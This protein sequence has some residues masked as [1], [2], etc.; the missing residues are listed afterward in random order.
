VTA[1]QLLAAMSDMSTDVIQLQ[2]G[3]YA[4]PQLI[5]NIDRTARPLTI[6]PVPGATVVFSGS[7]FGVPNPG[8]FPILMGTASTSAYITIQDITFTGY[9][10]NQSGVF[11]FAAYAH[12]I[13]LNGLTFENLTSGS[14]V[15]YHDWAVYMGLNSTAPHDITIENCTVIGTAY[16]VSA[17]QADSSAAIYNITV[18]GCSFSGVYYAFYGSTQTGLTLSDLTVNSSNNGFYVATGSTGT[19]SDINAPGIPHSM[20]SLTDGG[21]NTW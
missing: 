17:F 20:G 15:P 6:E 11:G 3:T 16:N 1:A 5:I 14:G 8:G 13:T 9:T 4:L 18:T 2:A 19:Y 7:V 12:N 21:G 10:L